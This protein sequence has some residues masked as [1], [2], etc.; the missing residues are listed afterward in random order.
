VRTVGEVNTGVVA[1]GAAPWFRFSR[2][3][4]SL[5]MAR[6]R[7]SDDMSVLRMRSSVSQ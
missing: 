1:V 4:A 7:R 6:S 3:N 2:L 5:T